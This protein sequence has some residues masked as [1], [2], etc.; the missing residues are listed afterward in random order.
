MK[1]LTE[2]L[3]SG[4]DLTS[5]DVRFAVTLLVAENVEDEHKAEFL[6]A[7]H[8][9]GESPDEIVAFVQTLM[10]RV[11]DPGIDE[12]KLPGPIVDVCG[13]GGDGHDFFNVSTAIT[14]IL[15]AGGVSVVKHGNRR[16]TSMSGSA[17]VLEAL[18]IPVR[19]QPN[20]LQETVQRHGL[21]FAFARDY[22]PAF[23]ALA[24][25]REHLARKSQR[26][27]FNLLG[28]LLNPAR[29]SRQLVGVFA[30]RWTAT[31]ADVLLRL[32][33]KRAMVVHGLTEDSGGMDDISIC[34]PTT[35]AELDNGKVTTAILDVQWLGVPRYPLA[36]LRGGTPEENAVTITNILSGELK[37]AKRDMT[38]V[39]AAA[40][41]VVA[42]LASNLNH[43][44]EFARELIDNGQAMEKLRALQAK[45]T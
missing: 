40:G 10:E 32:N 19:L 17:D 24:A 42:G 2:K 37:G 29:P 6:T 26:T 12:G 28:P 44:I 16:V 43:G 31:F 36:E 5:N 8:E 45:A 20:E 34:G 1:A 15:A 3:R 7:L 11:I 22:H 33:R 38:V 21:C 25:M 39:N 35:V 27:I 14:F 30:P 4:V 23:R 18:K 9:K 41:F 13:T